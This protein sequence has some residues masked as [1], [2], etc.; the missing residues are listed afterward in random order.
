[1]RAELNQFILLILIGGFAGWAAGMKGWGV[2]IVLCCYTAWLLLRLRDL[3]IWVSADD[4][5]EA[6]ESTGVWG[7]LFDT[8][9]SQRKKAHK[10]QEELH[11]ILHRAQISINSIEEAVVVTTQSGA[12]QWI[13]QSASDLLGLRAST[14]YQHPLT[15]LMRDPGFVRYFNSGNFEKAIEISSPIKSDLMLQ[16]SITVFGAGRDRLLIARDITRVHNLEQMRKD[17]VANVSH[18]LRTPLT[19]IKGYLET[20]LDSLDPESQRGLY[21]GMVQM[22][23]QTNRMEMLVADLLLLAKLET[24]ATH[25]T[26]TPVKVPALLLQVYND[27]QAINDEKQH[28]IQLDIDEDL[29]LLGIENEL[30]SAFSNLTI[31]AVKYT[32]P[33]GEILIR[34]WQDEDGVHLSVKDSGIGIDSRHIPRLT[35]RFYRADPSRHSKT[36][37]TGLGLAIVKHVLIHH[38]ANLEVV[39]ELNEGSEFICH[40]PSRL[41]IRQNKTKDNQSVA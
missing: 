21:R 29:L 38:D 11:D 23:Q 28:D 8:L 17:F 16:I 1:W 6:P 36:G 25:K 19:V 27:A 33:E 40:F 24:E 22:N 10:H 12:I 26:V 7:E 31:N 37:G 39:S 35:E 41:A 20:Y 32:P 14:D 3:V 13:N 4:N 5:S 34:W 18:E 9:N 15:N 2:A 30:R